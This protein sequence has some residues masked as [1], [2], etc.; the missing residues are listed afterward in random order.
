MQ[1][2][3]LLQSAHIVVIAS[4]G[5][6]AFKTHFTFEIRIFL[7][8]LELWELLKIRN[9]S[10]EFHT[11]KITWDAKKH[12]TWMCVYFT[13]PYK[14]M[15]TIMLVCFP[16]ESR[17]Q[18]QFSPLWDVHRE[19][20]V[21]SF[22]SGHNA[23]FIANYL[24][25]LFDK[26]KGWVSVLSKAFECECSCRAK[27]LRLWPAL[28]HKHKKTR[29]CVVIAVPRILPIHSAWDFGCMCALSATTKAF[30]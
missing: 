26:N 22:H 14:I 28:L 29:T 7:S 9:G 11:S 1:T 5:L 17:N 6:F 20:V 8:C 25:I 13:P 2:S 19:K 27:G 23:G 30:I 21:S 16:F 24:S 12:V 18:F 3:V 4:S 15:C 10:E